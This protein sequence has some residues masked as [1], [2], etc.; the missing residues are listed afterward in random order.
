MTVILLADVLRRLVEEGVSIRDLRGVL[1]SLAQVAHAEKDPLNLAELVRA[2][3]RRALTH[4]LT[5]G[6]VDLEVVL[7]DPM[8][9]DTIR[10]AISRTAAEASLAGPVRPTA[11]VTGWPADMS[12][13]RE[14]AMRAA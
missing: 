14:T 11:C 13:A 7:L 8:I 12:P 5:E 9:E 3:M 4:Q 1:E 6:G 2:N 10:G